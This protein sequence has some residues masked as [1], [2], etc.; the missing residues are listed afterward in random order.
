MEDTARIRND[1]GPEI[2]IDGGGR[3]TLSG[4]GERRILYMNAC[5][6]A[7]VVLPSDSC[8]GDD[9]PHLT[10]Q[11]LTFVDGN[12]TG[13]LVDPGEGGGGAIFVLGGRL[14]VVS[15]RFFRNRCDPTGP[16]IGG[17]AVRVVAQPTRQPAYFVNSTFG[18]SAELAGECANGGAIS[19]LHASLAVYN[20]TITHN[21]AVG[22]GANPARAGT[23]G[24]GSGGAIY[25]DGTDF[26]VLVAGS[27][28]EGNQANEGGGAIF[29]V[30]NDR[31]G[32]LHI[33]GSRLRGNAS[34]GFETDGF[35]GI[36]FLG[37]HDPEIANS[38]LEP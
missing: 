5:D 7:Q 32:T 27:R 4:G 37:A 25:T 21:R 12:S 11:N 20:S 30:S 6:E 15:S 2:V 36:F 1:T 26:T 33:D 34:G 10:V 16:D 35:P 9:L 19:G 17:A 8:W 22:D 23:P 24:G 29:F 3:V 14:K 28:I 31:T 13:D 18:G 38:T